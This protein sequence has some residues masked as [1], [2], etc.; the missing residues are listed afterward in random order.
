MEDAEGEVSEDDFSFPE[1]G[2]VDDVEVADV[3]EV[4]EK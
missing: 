4:E 3:E 1:E 2:V